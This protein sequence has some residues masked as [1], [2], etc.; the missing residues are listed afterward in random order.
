MV[1]SPRANVAAITASA[2]ITR[3]W[4]AAAEPAE[5]LVSRWCAWSIARPNSRGRVRLAMVA[6]SDVTIVSLTRHG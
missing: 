4:L 5:P 2:I 1:S 6:S 3:V